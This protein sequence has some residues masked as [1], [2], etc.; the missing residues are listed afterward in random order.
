M[1][2]PG[3]GVDTLSAEVL[4]DGRSGPPVRLTWLGT[5]GFALEH[6]GFA[7]LFDPYLTRASL[8]ACALGRP[9]SDEVRLQ[10][11]IPRADAIVVGH[12]HFDHALDVP[13]LARRTGARVFGSRSC[14][15][16]CAGSGVNPAQVEDVESALLASGAIVHEVGP[17][18]LEFYASAHSPLLAG[19]IP[20][21][22]E[23]ADCDD[24][25]LRVSHYRC[26]AVFVVRATVAGR[27]FVHVGSAHILDDRV[28]GHDGDVLLL[29]TAGWQSTQRFPERVIRELSPRAIVLSHWDNFFTPIEGAAQAFPAMQMHR[30]TERLAR[31]SRDARVGII[32]RLEPLDV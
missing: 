29:C 30:F 9:R 20:F 24:V 16:L 22:G 32:P 26:G 7:V 4:R 11:Y 27:S 23:I 13:A 18:R 28:R 3:Y 21:P 5:A 17:F 31:A 14:T 12:T 6:E 25:P 10:K 19:R 8:A 1:K 15:A 2:H